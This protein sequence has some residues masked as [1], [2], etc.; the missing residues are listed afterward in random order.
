MKTSKINFRNKKTV[1]IRGKLIAGEGVIIGSNVIIEGNVVLG[2]NAV[3]GDY[4]K[5]SDSSVGESTEIRDYS[6]LENSTVGTH[7][8]VGP[9]ARLRPDSSVGNKCQIGNFVEI[10]NSNISNEVRINHMAFIGD[11]EIGDGVTIG[12]GVITCN[13]D[14]IKTNKTIISDGAYVGSNV[15]LIAPIKIFKNAVIG[16]GSTL[17]QDAPENKLTIARVRQK[18]INGWEG[19]KK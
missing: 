4:V 11:T 1:E 10:K 5:I 3:L 15:N 19:F 13:H 16:S 18:V 9:Y 14:G 17:S 2:D 12:A 6:I 7:S 8:F